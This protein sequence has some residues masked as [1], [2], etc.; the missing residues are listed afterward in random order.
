MTMAWKVIKT[1]MITTTFV[2]MIT[3]ILILRNDDEND[4]LVVDDSTDVVMTKLL[5]FNTSYKTGIPEEIC[6][7]K[8]YSQ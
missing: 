3:I 1:L 2:M 6:R 8:K 4:D 5:N 7:N